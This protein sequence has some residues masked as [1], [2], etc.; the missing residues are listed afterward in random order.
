MKTLQG[1][2]IR[3]S[4]TRHKFDTAL[5]EYLHEVSSDGTQETTGN[6]TELGYYV[7]K[8]GKRLLFENDSGFVWVATYESVSKAD[9]EFETH[10]QIYSDFFSEED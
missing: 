3:Q 2:E 5:A 4:D 10:D 8:F 9:C 6:V 7:T 1:T